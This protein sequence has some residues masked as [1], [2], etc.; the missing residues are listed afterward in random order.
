MKV[1]QR[2]ALT[3]ALVT[4]A[5]HL[6]IGGTIL[7]FLGVLVALTVPNMPKPRISRGGRGVL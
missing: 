1:K 2:I 3:G 7:G 4:G 5:K 6:I